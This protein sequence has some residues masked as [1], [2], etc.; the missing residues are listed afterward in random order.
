MIRPCELD[1]HPLYRKNYIVPTPALDAFFHAVKRCIR[2]GKPGLIVYAHPRFGKTYAVRYVIA[3]L[4]KAFPGLIVISLDASRIR[5]TSREEYYVTFLVAA[6][7]AA[8]ESGTIAKKKRRLIQTLIQRVEV[9]K[10]TL[11]V[12][13]VDEAQKWSIDDYEELRDVHDAVEKHGL[14]LVTFLIGQPSLLAQKAALR[15][16]Q[17]TQIT[18]RFMTSELRFS[19]ISSVSEFAACLQGYDSSI[20]PDDTDWTY[21]RFF[22]PS[23]W[24]TGFRLVNEAHRVHSSFREAF[25]EAKLPGELEVPMQYVAFAV[26]IALDGSLEHDSAEYRLS[27]AMWKDAVDESAFIDGEREMR[28]GGVF[29]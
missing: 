20:F 6:G 9:S 8:P 24:Q 19:G 10:S 21:T 7:H 28:F 5:G 2:I 23:A 17:N 18:A 13:F 14:R 15:E 12:L 11:I 22:V 27:P 26:Q 16:S 29:P 25:L 1:L 3:L 4:H